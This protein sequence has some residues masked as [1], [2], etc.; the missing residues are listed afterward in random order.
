MPLHLGAPAFLYNGTQ[1]PVQRMRLGALTKLDHYTNT[2]TCT[3]NEIS[4]L[5]TRHLRKNEVKMY[6][7][8]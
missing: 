1:L 3:A 2:C 8:R 7:S 6:F 5:A 4:Y